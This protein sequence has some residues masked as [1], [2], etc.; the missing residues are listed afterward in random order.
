M[1]RLKVFGA[2]LGFYETVVAAPSMKAAL[3]AWGAHQDLFHSGAAKVVSDAGAV[4]AALAQPG[5]VLRRAV[6]SSEAYGADGGL[7]AL[8]IPDEPRPKGS[9]AAKPGVT[10]KPQPKAPPDRAALTRAEA[11]L[12]ARRRDHEAAK[13]EL[14]DRRRALEA[15]ATAMRRAFEADERGLEKARAK[16][17]LDYRRAGG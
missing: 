15:E 4:A 17:A 6:G 11:A 2:N 7:G 1:A 9:P 8:K 16:A 13:A 3:H 10:A 12:A 14:D 5:V